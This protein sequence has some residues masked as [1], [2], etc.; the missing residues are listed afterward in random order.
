MA[1]A[2]ADRRVGHWAAERHR[3]LPAEDHH[4]SAQHPHV[5]HL[6]ARD[7]R[8]NDPAGIEDR[9]GL[10]GTRLRPGVLGSRGAGA[11]GHGNQGGYEERLIEP[12]WHGLYFTA[13]TAG[14]AETL[15]AACVWLCI[16]GVIGAET[17][18]S[19]LVCAG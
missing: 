7:Q 19:G 11:A 17:F 13:D 1:I 15:W 16:A 8:A 10:S 5:G 12:P 9:G 14:A 3:W 2:C 18:F 4:V 6:P